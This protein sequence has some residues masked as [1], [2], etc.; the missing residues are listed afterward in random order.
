LQRVNACIG[1]KKSLQDWKLR[2]IQCGESATVL[3]LST[4]HPAPPA[5]TT[6]GSLIFWI[7]LVVIITVAVAGAIVLSLRR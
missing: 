1:F 5:H 2:H 6:D 4:L 7:W 3:L